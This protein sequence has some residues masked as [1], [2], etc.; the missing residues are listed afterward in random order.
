MSQAVD[1]TAVSRV[2]GI[3]TQF[4]DFGAGAV[5][6]LP[7]RIALIG[8]GCSL[9]SYSTDKRLVTS[10]AEVAAR[11]GYGSPLHLASLMLF[12]LNGDG[13]GSIPVT[14]YP[15]EDDSAGV[16]AAGQIAAVGVQ[17]ETASYVIK[18]AEIS[19]TVVVEE[20][21]TADEA[22]T[23]IR[24]AIIGELNMP[25]IPGVIA[26]G[27]LPLEAKWAGESGNDIVVEVEG[28]AYGI[29]FTST[30]CAGGLVNPDIQDA[31]DQIGQVWET[32]I[33]NCLNYDDTTTLDLIQTFGDGRWLPLEKKPLYAISGTGDDRATRTVITDARDDD[34]INVLMSAPGCNNLPAQIAARAAARVTKQAVNNPPQDY[35]SLLSGL[36]AGDDVDQEDYINR[37]LAVQ[38]GSCTTI[39]TSGEIEMNDTVTMYHPEGEVPPAYRYL[40]DVVKLQ[41]IVYNVRLIFESE[42]WKGSPLLPDST[43]TVN[44]T[45]K[46]PKDALSALGNLADNLA[47]QAIIADAE[48]TKESMVVQIDSQN[49][50][51]LN[52]TFPVKLSG[53]VEIVSGDINFG[54][55][56]G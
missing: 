36:V 56:F 50:K 21:D 39:L 51:R 7:Q 31:L 22:L 42:D 17:T 46:K 30:D 3:L 43:P 35:N 4:K 33:V 45:A 6:F 27:A 53:N 25:V 10:A 2:V 32:C 41:N 28:D 54:F 29:T 34:K 1:A 49:P 12:P 11:Y 48:F 5:R 40:V 55:Y 9:S 38:A 19:V 37:D 24:T 47:L 18:C 14:V 16:P 52:W 13:V 20:G 8:Q 44:P 23:A 26:A 15:L